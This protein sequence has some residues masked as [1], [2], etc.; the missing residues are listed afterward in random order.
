MEE[1]KTKATGASVAD[2]L[3][4][5]P[6]AQVRE[7]CM[8]IAG[9]MQTAAKAEPR[10]WGAHI[11]GFGLRRYV[12]AGGREADWPLIGF[13][14]RKQNITL[15]VMVE[16]EEYGELLSKLGPHSCGKGCLYLKRLSEVHVPTLKKL[17]RAS[18]R[19]KIKAQSAARPKR[20]SVRARAGV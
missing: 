10:M 9:I 20:A 6:D 12:Y 3:S 15:Y 8:T 11:V 14:P 2:F 16:S 18:V 1:A 17:V 5:I 13:S 7:D 19:H 4:A